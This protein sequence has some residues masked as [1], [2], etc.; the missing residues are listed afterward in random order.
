MGEDFYIFIL[1]HPEMP[2]K[3]K[4]KK[5]TKEEDKGKS[6]TEK[7]VASM[8]E[9]RQRLLLRIKELKGNLWEEKICLLKAGI[10]NRTS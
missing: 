4:K 9:L 1:L 8:E 10:I 5:K 7:G 2:V 6:E 3:S